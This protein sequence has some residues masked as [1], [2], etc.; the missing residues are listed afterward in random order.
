MII[1]SLEKSSLLYFKIFLTRVN[2]VATFWADSKLLTYRAADTAPTAFGVA[3]IQIM[4]LWDSFPI[5]M[6]K[7]HSGWVF[8]SKMIIWVKI[9]IGKS[10]DKQWWECQPFSWSPEWQNPDLL[11]QNSLLVS[12]YEISIRVLWLCEIWASNSKYSSR[13]SSLKK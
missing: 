8:C 9:W 7:I 10:R 3:D 2:P 4:L 1:F 11:L 12:T 13:T 5:K 6:C